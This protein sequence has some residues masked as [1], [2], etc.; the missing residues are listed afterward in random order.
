MTVTAPEDRRFL[1]ARVKP[2]RRHGGWRARLRVVRVAALACVL[3]AAGYIAVRTVAASGVF[4]VSRVTVRGN[5]HLATGEVLALVDDLKGQSLLFTRLPEWRRR[6]LGSPWVREATLRRLMPSTVEITIAERWP[7]GVG[8]INGQLFLVDES[9]VIIDEYGPQ[10]ADFDLPVIDGLTGVTAGS[11][12]DANARRAQLAMRLLDAVR[13]KPEL[14]RRISQ[15]DVSDPRNAVV[16]L[17]KDTVLVKLGDDRFVERL[18]A[19]IELAPSLHER[20]PDME[21]VDLRFC[22]RVYVGAGQQAGAG[23]A[24]PKGRRTQPPAGG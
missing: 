9:G 2:G 1:R 7:I 3:A 20:A 15:V 5:V 22:E 19:Y 16:V 13:A 23:A 8:R 12:A 6:L 4:A 11:G 10:Y 18:L 24:A 17:D 21:Y 14:A